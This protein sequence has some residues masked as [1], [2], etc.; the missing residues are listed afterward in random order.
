MTP[1]PGPLRDVTDIVAGYNHTCALMRSGGVKC[2]GYNYAGQL[3]NG[4]SGGLSLVPVNVS[5][6]SSGVTQITAGADHTCALLDTGAVKCWGYSN[7]GQIGDGTSGTNRLTPVNV[8][9][10]SSGVTKISAGGE[11]TCAL[12]SAGEVKCWGSNTG[13]QIGDGT[14]GTARRTP[15]SVSGLSSGVTQI[16]AGGEHTCALLSAGGMKCWGYNGQGQI[17][18][19]SSG[20]NVL[21]PVSVSGLAS[22]VARISNTCALLTT[23][24]VKCWGYNFRGRIGDGTS[25]NF[26]LVPV[27]VVGLSSGVSRITEGGGHT[28]ALLVAG[29]LKCWGDNFYGSI[30]DG[31]SVTEV[32]TPVNVSEMTAGVSSITAGSDHTCA[33]LGTGE[34]KCWGHN[35]TGQI[36]DGTQVNRRTPVL[37]R[38]P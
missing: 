14:S 2:W 28:C 12:L 34:V 15:V 23:G 21:V 36:G 9:G 10:L 38:V 31:T 37:V 29:G 24:G 11:H 33:L 8:S 6:L 16:A 32:L 4:S 13:G 22:G 5:G 19:G 27:D 7:Y 35:G 30:G 1:T 17:G 26:R 3:G 18:N 20:G 25:G